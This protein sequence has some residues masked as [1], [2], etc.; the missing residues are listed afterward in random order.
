MRHRPDIKRTD[1]ERTTQLASTV[2]YHEPRERSETMST[3]SE[4]YVSSGTTEAT[5][6]SIGEWEKASP[7]Q[8]PTAITSDLDGNQSDGSDSG[9]DVQM[10]PCE[11]KRVSM[12]P[13]TSD[14]P[15]S[16]PCAEPDSPNAIASSSESSSESEEDVRPSCVLL[17]ALH[18]QDVFDIPKFGTAG[19]PKFRHARLPQQIN[20]RN[21]NVQQIKYATI[22][23]VVLYG[24]NGA[25]MGV[26]DTAEK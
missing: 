14:E 22:S 18:V 2:E 5:S 26:L 25:T 16:L 3:S 13:T 7:I 1:S 23:D 21:L 9:Q 19:K 10:H 15:H 12:P 6:P 8:S 17:N 11:S 20:L 24:K 4:S